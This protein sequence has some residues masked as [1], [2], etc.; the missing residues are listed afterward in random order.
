[1]SRH[2]WLKTV[3]HYEHSAGWVIQPGRGGQGWT[4]RTVSGALVPN[5]RDPSGLWPGFEAAAAHV[6]KLDANVSRAPLP[7]WRP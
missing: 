6:A 1:M 5:E 2:H 7:R 4:L 3:T